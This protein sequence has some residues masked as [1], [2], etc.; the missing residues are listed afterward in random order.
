M[1][2]RLLTVIWGEAFVDRFLK[3]ALR[4]L[5]SAGNL[6]ALAAR[7]RAIYALYTT[8]D[9]A[10]RIRQHPLFIQAA[11]VVDFRICTFSLS[12]IDPANP[13]SHWTIWE[14]AFAA[15]QGVDE[16]V[17]TVAGDH[18]FSNGT[19]TRWAELFE[20]GHLAIFSPGIQVALETIREELEARFGRESTIDLT[21]DQTRELMFRHLHPV[22]ISMFRDSPRWMTHPEYHLRPLPGVGFTQNI[23]TSH[24]VA[25]HATKMRMSANFCPLEKLD[26]VAFEPCRFLSVEPLLKNLPLYFRPWR[27]DEDA[28][29]HFGA[30][31]CEH[32]T[33]AN[34]RES[35][36]AH[37]YALSSAVQPAGACRAILGGRFYVGQMLTSRAIFRLWQLLRDNGLNHAGMWLAVAHMH[38]RLRRRLPVPPDATVFVPRE[39]YLARVDGREVAHLLADGGKGLI[40][41]CRSHT[42]PRPVDLTPGDCLAEDAAGPIRTLAG[43][44]YK[45]DAAGIT[46]VLRGP[47]L[48]DGLT[49]YVID[50]PLTVLRAEPMTARAAANIVLGSVRH[51]ARRMVARGG[52]AAMAVLRHNRRAYAIARQCYEK[53]HSRPSLRSQHRSDAEIGDRARAAFRQALAE[54]AVLAFRDL[55]SL[56][57][58]QV[59]QGSGITSAVGSRLAECGSVANGME[60]LRTATRAAP[61]LAEAWLELGCGCAAAGDE[62]GAIDAFKQAGSLAPAAVRYRGEADP[63]VL[64]ALALAEIMINQGQLADALGTLDAVMALPP[65]PWRCHLLRARLLLRLGRPREAMLAFEA[66]LVRDQ[67]TPRIADLP[68]TFTELQQQLREGQ[69]QVAALGAVDASSRRC[70]SGTRQ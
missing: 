40:G 51:S 8:A 5:L 22:N 25:F 9:D 60:L 61:R 1:R 3:I 50:N 38:A 48:V 31:A 19:L 70:G 67:I 58:Q 41:V 66:S 28:L 65:T 23:L 68:A 56:Y 26:R 4:S 42:V 15:V 35:G 57:E 46:R 63:R 34:V 6:P 11:E 53:L 21:L 30:W 54:R 37:V 47:L 39:S 55:Y 7:G 49:V 32:I 44:G 10:A 62:D 52:K 36:I 43:R 2:F 17:I 33:P 24:A 12:E 27:M 69:D 14:R 59:L 45:K 29:T 13:Y 20:S 64:A 18:L 16:W